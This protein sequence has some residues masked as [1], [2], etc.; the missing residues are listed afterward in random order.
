MKTSTLLLTGFN[1]YPKQHCTI[2][3]PERFHQLSAVI[4]PTIARG[5]GCSYGDAALNTQ[6]Q[7]LLTERLNRFIAFDPQQGILTVEAGASLAEILTLVTPQGW[8]LPVTPGTQRA[9]IGGCIATDAHGKNH[10]HVGSF[11]QHILGLELMLNHGK[12]I[13]CSPQQQADI[14][15]AT[16]GGMGLTGIITSAT[17]QLTR[18]ASHYLQVTHLISDNLAQTIEQLTNNTEPY[19]IAWLD[20]LNVEKKFS[21]ITMTAHH[22]TPAE[23]PSTLSTQPFA[24]LATRQFSVPF[25]CPNSLL[26]NPLMRAF[27]RFYA[28]K[29][30]KKTAASFISHYQTFFYPLDQLAEWQYLYGKRGFIQYQ[31]ALPSEHALTS[32]EQLCAYLKTTPYPVYL[33]S[34]K[35]LGAEN[36]G[37][38]SFPLR[39]FTLALDLPLIDNGLFTVLDRLDEIVS[40]VGG[41]IYLA[42]DARLNAAMFRT[43]YPRHA[44]WLTIKNQIDPER[45]FISSLARRLGI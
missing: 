27:N 11:G 29:Q 34:L 12:T 31:C 43:M 44:N 15:W 6:G 20:L 25:V 33:A 28:W 7:V 37:M 30:G 14:F 2:V 39:G 32:L 8:F 16:I 4:Q 18:I 5:R 24:A 1:R 45:F 22:L 38:L 36:Q 19:G 23:L 10:L 35:Q 40:T 3:R 26:N 42:K 17:I 21:G 9:S 13:F 41:R